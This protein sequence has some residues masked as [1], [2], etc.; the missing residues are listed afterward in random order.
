MADLSDTSHW[1]FNC[2]CVRVCEWAAWWM[3]DYETFHV[4]RVPW[5]QQSV[6][7]WW[8]SDRIIWAVEISFVL[9]CF[10]GTA[11]HNNNNNNK[12][13]FQANHWKQRR[14]IFKV[15]H[16]NLYLYTI[17]DQRR[18]DIIDQVEH[19]RSGRSPQQV[20][21]LPPVWDLLLPLA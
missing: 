5:F 7:C 16:L 21:H 6:K 17:F 18:L 4:C 14:P 8:P 3:A 19:G 15:Q 20:T 12:S 13:L 10:T 9:R 11:H 1:W 2:V